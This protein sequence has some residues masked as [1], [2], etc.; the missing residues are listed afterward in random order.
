MVILVKSGGEAAM[1]E[2]RAA[3]SACAPR[4]D[5]R[6]WDDATVDPE[7]VRY[8]LVW[9]P[10]AG[11]LAQYPG[12]RAVFSTG[13]GVDHVVTDPAYPAGVPLI[14][15]YTDGFAQRMGEYAC[16]ACL[17]LLRDL[18]QAIRNQRARDWVNFE[19]PRT[20]PQTRIGI[21]GLGNLG[22]RA[23]EM[24]VG[25][26]FRTAGW[27]NTRKSVPG[28]E[29]FAS[30]G[31][32]DAFL[33]R[34]DILVNLLPDTP[35]TRA[36]LNAASFALMPPGAGIVN[37]GRGPQLVLPDLVAALDAGHL[38]GAV[39]DVFDTEPPP[40]DSPAWTHPKIIMTPHCAAFGTRAERAAYVAGAIAAIERGDTPPNLY[41][42]QRGY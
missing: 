8:A 16:M 35:D 2:W 5:V 17:A 22:L 3:F 7:I 11:R 26:G 20:I 33:A 10:Q 36:I 30:P 34:T 41:D 23:A 27:S 12:L 37:A 6:G 21:M 40:P 25:L 15:M 32:R 28:V 42:V 29:S 4:L 9:Q 38:A 39:L 13:A 18:P 19:V 14:R 1:P 31:E 24:L